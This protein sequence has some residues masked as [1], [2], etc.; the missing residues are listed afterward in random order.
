M[1]FR[2]KAQQRYLFAAAERGDI[3]KSVPREFAE[4]TSKKQFARM[5]EHIKHMASG[6]A[7]WKTP[8][9]R[10]EERRK[11][12]AYIEASGYRQAPWQLDPE[13]PPKQKEKKRMAHGGMICPKC[14]CAMG[15]GDEGASTDDEDDD[16]MGERFA[17]AILRKRKGNDS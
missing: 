2:S 3:P 17:I 11:M 15:N 13:T 1:P 8:A 16:D 14:G 5:P 7:V 12:G 10:K 4:A 9:E 6:G